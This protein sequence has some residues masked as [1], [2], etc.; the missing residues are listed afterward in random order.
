MTEALLILIVL[1]IG[2]AFNS[3]GVFS[4]YRFPDVYTRLHGVAKCTTFGTVFVSFAAF[5][6]ALL[7][8]LTTGEWRFIVF[9]IHGIVAVFVLLITNA[10]V[11]HAISR[12]AWRSGIRPEPC[13]IDVLDEKEREAVL[14]SKTAEKEA[15]I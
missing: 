3:L 12:A 10:T 7:R 2:L 4:M 6:F 15:L 13:A 5:L 11:S 1:C 8:F 14:K 9:I